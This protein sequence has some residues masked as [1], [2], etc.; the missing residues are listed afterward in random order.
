MAEAGKTRRSEFDR[1]TCRRPRSVWRWVTI[2][3]GLHANGHAA[4]LV[5]ARSVVNKDYEAAR[6]ARGQKPE[7]YVF[8]QGKFF[9][10]QVVDRTLERMR[11]VEIARGVAPH[12]AE[13]RYFPVANIAQADLIL[14]VHWGVTV[15]RN[16]ADALISYSTDTQTKLVG[17]GTDYQAAADVANLSGLVPS[18]MPALWEAERRINDLSVQQSAEAGFARISDDLSSTS[19]ASLLGFADVAWEENRATFTSTTLATINAMLDEDRYFII[20]MAY[21]RRALMNDKVLKRVS[22]IRLSLRSA[23]VNFREALKHLGTIGGELFGTKSEKM[24]IQEARPNDD[25]AK[26]GKVSVGELKVIET[27]APKP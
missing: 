5:F 7:T 8:Y 14:V 18:S 9:E 16:K 17:A 10:G 26:R 22:S 20:V 4:P 15:G 6:A 13:Q 27:P 25:A 12:L 11:F 19:N 21:D 23:G 1:T 24:L 2:A 3:V